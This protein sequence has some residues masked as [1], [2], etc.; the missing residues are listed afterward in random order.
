MLNGQLGAFYNLIA[1]LSA[2]RW[3]LTIASTGS[4]MLLVTAMIAIGLGWGSLMGNPYLML[5]NAIPP[6]RTGVYMGIV[7]MFIVIPMMVEILVV[8]LAYRPLLGGDPRNVLLLGGAMM[9]LAAVATMLVKSPR[10]IG[11][12]APA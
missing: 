3:M 4:I 2:L 7:N 12:A 10:A 9:L 11:A 5:A 1:C 8:W 6:E